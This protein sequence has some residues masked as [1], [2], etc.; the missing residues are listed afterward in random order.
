MI[1]L[2]IDTGGTYTDAVALDLATGQVL[3]KG[4]SPTTKE[5][6]ALGIIAALATLPAE[7]VAQ[8]GSVALSTTLATNA[9][10][11]N[12]GGRAKLVLVGSSS[13]V[14]QRIDA[15]GK[16]GLRPENVLCIDTL[17]S[18]DGRRVEIPDWDEVL[19]Q[20]ADWFRDAEA[21]SVA[22]VFAFN[23]GAACEKS[24]KA[25]LSEKLGLPVVMASELV[26]GLNVME[27]G[28]T[29]L[30][31]ARLLPV[32]EEFIKAVYEAVSNKNNI[33]RMMIVRSDSSLMSLAAAQQKPVE[34]ILSGPTAS[35]LGGMALSGSQNCLI[36]DMGGTTT[37]ISIVRDGKPKMAENGIRIGG[38]G[39]QIK[40][41]Y[42]DTFAL[43]G[44]SAIR[45]EQGA[46]S[47]D[48]HRAIPICH[49][50]ARWSQIKEELH[51]LLG[52]RLELYR[53][54]HEFLCLAKEP[55]DLSRYESWE[56]RLLD[57]LR[58]GPRMI[59]YLNGVNGIDK[60]YL[61][62]SRLEAEGIIIRSTITPTDMMHLRGDYSSFD[63]E[64]SELAVRYF[65][66]NLDIFRG[67]TP[68]D[69]AEA[70]YDLVCEKLYSNI[71][72]VMLADSDPAVFSQTPD[73]QLS[74]LIQGAWRGNLPGMSLQFATP[75]TLV[76]TGAPTH[77]FLPR[78]AEALGA[79]CIMPEHAEVAN[80]LG[81]ALADISARVQVEIRPIVEEGVVVGYT[82]HTPEGMTPFV[83]LG[84]A[85]QCALAA[86]RAEAEREVRARGAIGEICI[87]SG[88]GSRRVVALD[89]TEVTFG[90]HAWAVVTADAR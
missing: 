6:L 16:F 18:Y 13:D 57:L 72:R 53:D 79:E 34:T 70:V 52:S 31:N 76:G 21:L 62:S 51:R 28:A 87:E 4:K 36:V 1:S 82:V 3:A 2:G 44:D 77:L 50:A 46:L 71:L 17:G 56:L 23:N 43:G 7:I 60:Y 27:R 75:L 10:V 20:H 48:S 15:E 69:F 61:H 66:A 29:A 5:N 54:F 35:T 74:R 81:A 14:L 47:L 80:A 89:G 45:V 49:A 65:I 19:S 40:G 25:A 85:K 24:A 42:V 11:E 33:S 84:E 9:C 58:D 64:A 26:N 32:I 88:I 22:E 90:V 8:A 86:A 83:E 12:V 39:T 41:V 59:E 73:K 63:T 67:K 68:A 55:S 30:L 78:V 37:D 38:W